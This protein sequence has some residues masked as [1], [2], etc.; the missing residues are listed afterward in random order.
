MDGT[1]DGTDAETSFLLFR[2]TRLELY[3]LTLFGTGWKLE[4]WNRSFILLKLW[5]NRGWNQH[6]EIQKVKVFILLSW[7]HSCNCV[8]TYQC[9][10]QNYQSV[11]KKHYLNF[12]VVSIRFH[13]RLNKFAV[14]L[15]ISDCEQLKLNNSSIPSSIPGS[16]QLAFFCTPIRS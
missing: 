2:R 13:P 4:G 3:L 12:I 10:T 8:L 7:K 14:I 15:Q 6:M 9:T 16:N 5:S 1:S 11:W